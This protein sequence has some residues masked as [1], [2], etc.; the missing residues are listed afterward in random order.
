M[1]ISIPQSHL[2]EGLKNIQSVVEKRTT[3]PILNNF[4]L[5]AKEKGIEISATDLEIE[6]KGFFSAKVLKSGSIVLPTRKCFEIVRG[7][8]ADTIDIKAEENWTKI[9][10]GKSVFKIPGLP[11]EEFPKFRA[12]DPFFSIELEIDMLKDMIDK[13]I[14]ASSQEE[15]R[16]ILSGLLL[17][18]K[19]DNISM[20]A[21]DGYRLAFVNRKLAL[22]GLERIINIVIPKKVLLEVRKIFSNGENKIF[23][24]V[25]QNEVVFKNNHTIL[26]SRL[27]EGDFPDYEQV[28]PDRN[29]YKV[30][31]KR[32]DFYQALRRVSLL[33]DEES[34]LVTIKLQANKIELLSSAP[35]LGEARD[36]L[37]VVYSGPDLEIRFNARYMMD[38]ISVFE[39]EYIAL[40]LQDSV[41]AI[42][43]KPL[44]DQSCFSVI[45]PM[46]IDQSS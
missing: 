10:A 26:S 44:E 12:K 2:Y 19:A 45:M 11:S 28:I 31:I 25:Q 16:S 7:I 13:T 21:A 43:I 17:A 6:Y 1:E 46:S 14:F 9:E 41:T 3:L 27:L 30:I 18:L 4:L 42:I 36:E 33:S 34:K 37:E 8:L 15:A 38:G 20:V 32:E 35:E 39:E 23:L 40:E 5:I 29:E 22:P 24:G